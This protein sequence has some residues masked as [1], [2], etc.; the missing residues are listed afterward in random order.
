MKGAVWAPETG[1][2]SCLVIA[3]PIRRRPRARK[4]AG[5]MNAPANSLALDDEVAESKAVAHTFGTLDS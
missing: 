4:C 1:E 3:L 2:R 5:A